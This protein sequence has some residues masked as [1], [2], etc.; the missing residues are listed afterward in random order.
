MEHGTS[1]IEVA[2]L[3]CDQ[4]LKGD[5]V[6]ERKF[7]QTG[8]TGWLSGPP[9]REPRIEVKRACMQDRWFEAM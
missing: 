1:R 3:G 2:R 6:T 9:S 5:M 7:G 4:D 8:R